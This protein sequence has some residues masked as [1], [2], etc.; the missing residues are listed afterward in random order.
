[1]YNFII[2]LTIGYLCGYIFFRLKVPGGMMVGSIVGVSIFNIM[3]GMAY[4]PIGAKVAAQIIA[5]AFIG[6]GLEKSDLIR[7]KDIFKPAFTILSGLIFLNI[8]IGFIIYYISPLDLVTSFMSAI[9]GGISDIPIISEEMGAD[10]AKVAAMQFVRLVF[11]IG[12]FPTMIKK[13]TDLK[14]FNKHVI[15]GTNVEA[16][17]R[18]TTTSNDYKDLILTLLIATIFGVLGRVLDIPSGTLVFSMVSVIVLNISTGRGYLPRAYKRLAQV[19]A[20]TYVGSGIVYSDLLEIKF[21]LL[22]AI[23]LVTGYAITCI[24]VGTFICRKFNMPIKDAMLACTP[25]GAS[26]MAL[27]ASDIGVKSADVIVIQVIRMVVVVSIFPQIIRII[28]SIFG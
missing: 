19:L 21:I 16:Y 6:V 27:I 1:M 26:D 2:T 25:A 24:C 13:I 15:E 14:Y 4:I 12:V 10:S 23:V 11:G 28:V 9:P 7:L 18:V 5:G 3:T 17:E 8:L 22:P 20:G